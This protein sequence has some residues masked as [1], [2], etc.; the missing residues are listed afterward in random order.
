MVSL[1]TFIGVCQVESR[2]KDCGRQLKQKGHIQ[3]KA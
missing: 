1:D 3:N 2:M